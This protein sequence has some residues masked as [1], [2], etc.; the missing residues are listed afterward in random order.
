MTSTCHYTSRGNHGV[1]IRNVMFPKGEIFE[2]KFN[3]FPFLKH[4]TSFPVFHANIG[5]NVYY[6][7]WRK[8]P[9]AYQYIIS[10]GIGPV[11]ISIFC[12]KQC[13]N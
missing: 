8:A 2:Q 1:K 7:K 11:R 10:A 5:E 4:A 9:K 6:G 12:G 13:Q 3:L